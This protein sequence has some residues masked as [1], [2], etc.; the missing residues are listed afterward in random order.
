MTAADTASIRSAYEGAL[1]LQ[2]AGRDEEAL[3]AYGAIIDR[4]PNL[5]EVHFQVAQLFLR[6]NKLERAI[7][8][9]SAA[10]RLK[11][12]EPDIWSVWADAVATLSDKTVRDRF[13]AALKSSPLDKRRKTALSSAV[14]TR[15]PSRPPLGGMTPA[16]LQS[17]AE[18]VDARRFAEAEAVAR[19]LLARHPKA[20]VVHD[21]LGVALAG[22][23]R[24]DEAEA[25][26]RA[27]ITI[28]PRLPEAHVNLARTLRLLK[29]PA[30][31]LRHCNAALRLAPGLGAALTGRGQC[32]AD[33]GQTDDAKADFQRA[34][35]VEPG[36]FEA[37]VALGKILAE[38]EMDYVAAEDVLRGA[39]DRG[40]DSTAL[41]QALGHVLAE[42]GQS[43]AALEQYAR[44]RELD[45]GSALGLSRSAELKQSLGRF[46]EAEAEFR[47]AIAQ[48]PD[49]GE[50]YRIWL[51][52][53][54]VTLDDPVVAEMERRFRDESQSDE[55]RANLGFALAKVMED[56]RAWD[57]VFA[58]LHP[59]NALMRKLRP[60]D[61]DKRRDLSARLLAS[62]RQTDWQDPAL[63]SDES[64]A[65]IFVTGMPRSGTTLVE[66]IISSHST[67]TGAGEVGVAGRLALKL[68]GG[69]TAAVRST[70]SIGREEY[71]A[72]GH[73]YHDYI[74]RHLPG[75]GI[76]TDKSIQTY[77]FLGVLKRALPK[78]RFVVVRRDPR[79][80][81]LSIYRNVFPEKAHR[82]AYDLRHLA[83]QFHQ[84]VE[85]IEFWREVAP[86][87]LYE[88]QYEDL[89]ANPEEETRKLVAAC[90]LD[91]EEG[92]LNFHQSERRVKTLSLYQ[93]RQ[94]MYR[95]ST[96]AW[97]RYGNELDELMA[98][99]G[100]RW[101]TDAAS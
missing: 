46:D 77:Q 93:V 51:T 75:A 78:A 41:R 22:L 10:A 101:T 14:A 25:A 31:A 13:L 70:A 71:A 28:D 59:A 26:G 19:R 63:M 48:H 16:D 32:H 84:F 29:R 38:D 100:P 61:A 52:A 88:V 2:A 57:R 5:A 8:H 4:H 39:L 66:Q 3:R 9:A 30:E 95:S 90:G 44:L 64:F 87:W 68:M 27:A 76:V 12:A 81:L 50:L 42:T 80:N 45:P 91:W 97:E 86:D 92:C 53:K 47:A 11:P 98:A 6:N 24:L 60:Y 73:A 23:G 43:E 21:L 35:E 96:H 33:M 85:A 7:R 49:R 54:K 56:N 69:E 17:L 67:V 1:R 72:V 18:P 15:G 79:D 36:N 99:L 65:P 74:A 34:I 83:D 82:Y 89:V 62:Y 55:T 37:R 58:Y 20:A 94:P 40:Q